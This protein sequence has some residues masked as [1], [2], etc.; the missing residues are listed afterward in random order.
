MRSR[1]RG[2]AGRTL[3]C[4]DPF[5]VTGFARDI[6]LPFSWGRGRSSLLNHSN[7]S[8][9]SSL[10]I[11]SFISLAIAPFFKSAGASSALR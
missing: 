3:S 8:A 9:D 6:S 1:R 5:S 7:P 11:S 2:D 4:K 10:R